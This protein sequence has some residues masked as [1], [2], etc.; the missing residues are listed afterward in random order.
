MQITGQNTF[1]QE[2]SY[3]NERMADEAGLLKTQSRQPYRN[4]PFHLLADDVPPKLAQWWQQPP[5]SRQVDGDPPEPFSG[6]VGHSAVRWWPVDHSIPGAAAF[7]VE[8]S[9]GWVA[10]TGDIRFHGARREDSRRLREEWARMGIDLLLCEGTRLGDPGRTVGEDEVRENALCL[11]RAAAGRL[12]VADFAARNLERRMPAPAVAYAQYSLTRQPGNSV[13]F[14]LRFLIS[15]V[16]FL[17]FIHRSFQM[18]LVKHSPLSVYLVEP[19]G[20]AVNILLD[21]LR[22]LGEPP[23]VNSCL[24]QLD[25]VR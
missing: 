4:R 19:P 8:T 12:V 18:G 10:Y 16:Q 23:C 13:E 2:W 1:L 3:C 25:Y 6:Q 24:Y 14:F 20:K 7:A 17:C 11:T 5:T 9:A 21:P 22:L 15:L